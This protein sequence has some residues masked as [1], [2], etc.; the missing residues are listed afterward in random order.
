MKPGG[1]GDDVAHA[2]F[3]RA[4]LD[5]D[6]L[7]E[8]LGERDELA[9]PVLDEAEVGEEARH[10]HALA[11][12]AEP[13]LGPLTARERERELRVAAAGRERQRERAAEARV[14]VGDGQRPVRL[15]EALDVRRAD[16]R[17]SSRRRGRRA[18][19]AR[20]RRASGP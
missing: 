17:R 18:R 14:H 7:G 15:A 3:H 19:S 6:G 5:R 2:Y 16:D 10:H 4:R 1:A 20:G 8:L 11:E 9:V 12:L 13:R